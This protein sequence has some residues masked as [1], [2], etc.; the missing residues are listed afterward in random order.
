MTK[1]ILM[2]VSNVSEIDSEN[3]TGVYFEEFAVPYLG[4]EHVGFDILVAS[5][6]GGVAPVDEDSYDCSNPMEWDTTKKYLDAT[7]K[8]E[9]VKYEEFDAIVLPGGHAPMFDEANSKYLGEI[10]SDFYNKG[11]L[12]AAI[13]HGP[14]GLIHA[15]KEDGEP[16]VKGKRVTS[17]TNKEEHIIHKDELMPFLLQSKL[18]ELGAKFVEEKPWSEHV[19]VDGNLITGQ[20]QKSSY[21]FADAIIDYFKNEV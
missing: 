20:N 13:C 19:E 11:K 4:F 9:E 6:K 16:L 7:K 5:L 8:L 1:K 18:V 3:K 10:V 17:F 15:K 14:A 12:V 2:V 21:V